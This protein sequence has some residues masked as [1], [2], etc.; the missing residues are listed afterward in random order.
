M[1][2]LAS[3][4]DFIGVADAAYLYTGAESAPL[5]SQ[6]QALERYLR[7]RPRAEAGRAEHIA[8][9][10]RCKQRLAELMNCG[11]DDVGLVGSASEAIVLIASGIDFKPGDNIVTNDLEFPQHGTALDPDEGARHR[12]APGPQPGLAIHA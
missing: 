9:E 4:Q 12:G 3:R 7:E 1:Q 11:A 5:Q 6:T 2:A 8:T 10:Q